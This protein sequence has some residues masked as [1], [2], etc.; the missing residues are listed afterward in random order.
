ME[1]RR[2]LSQK[3]IPELVLTNLKTIALNSLAIA[4]DETNQEVGFR[5]LKRVLQLFHQMSMSDSALCRESII[6]ADELFLLFQEWKSIVSSSADDSEMLHLIDF[7]IS[8]SSPSDVLPALVQ[9]SSAHQ[10]GHSLFP[11][12]NALLRQ[13]VNAALK[14]GKPSLFQLQQ[15]R[16][17]Y[18]QE[19]RILSSG[20]DE[21]EQSEA[22]IWRLMSKGSLSINK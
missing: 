1:N 7:I 13:G 5:I 11:R 19:N 8:E 17:T 9:W 22:G 20:N 21:A 18:S 15:A 14:S 6:V 16:L 12:L 10:V 3:H 4:K 2:L